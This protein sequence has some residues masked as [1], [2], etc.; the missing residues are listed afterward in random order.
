M[1]AALA[2]HANG[3]LL[4]DA[5]PGRSS[6]RHRRQRGRDGD[7]PGHATSRLVTRHLRSPPRRPRPPTSPRPSRRSHPPVRG[8]LQLSNRRATRRRQSRGQDPRLPPPSEESMTRPDSKLV[9]A[10]SHKT[11][12][13][14]PPSVTEQP[15]PPVSLLL[16][17]FD[18]RHQA[19]RPAGRAGR[20]AHGQRYGRHADRYRV[21]TW[22]RRTLVAD[23][24]IASVSNAPA[25]SPR[26]VGPLRSPRGPL[27]LMRF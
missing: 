8:L 14:R 16:G 20:Q 17:R 12:G 1:V 13:L 15:S 3:F 7:L 6:R 19:A 11:Q 5:S 18:R 23:L 27:G 21:G 24:A 26:G 25:P 4:Q 10:K 2:Q 22:Y 9:V